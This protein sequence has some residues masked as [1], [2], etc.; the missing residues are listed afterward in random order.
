MSEKGIR[1]A[2]LFSW[3]RAARETM[4]VYRKVAK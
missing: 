1:R 2:A 3:E 4:N